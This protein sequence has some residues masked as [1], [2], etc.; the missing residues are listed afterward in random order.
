VCLILQDIMAALH[1]PPWLVRS[2]PTQWQ[3]AGLGVDPLQAY[4]PRTSVLLKVVSDRFGFY[5]DMSITR[6]SGDTRL[7]RYLSICCVFSYKNDTWNL[8]RRLSP[9]RW[10]VQL[11]VSVVPLGGFSNSW[12]TSG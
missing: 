12:A 11:N 3:K 5:I 4:P 2:R 9:N 6:H 10:S 8:L 1:Q 7:H